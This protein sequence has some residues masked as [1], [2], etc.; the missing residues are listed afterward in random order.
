MGWVWSKRVERG[1]E[2]DSKER[3]GRVQRWLAD[4]TFY[5]REE[6]PRR[7]YWPERERE[8]NLCEDSHKFWQ[9]VLLAMKNQ[10]FSF[11]APRFFE[12][13][14]TKRGDRNWSKERRG[15]VLLV[16]KR[17][18]D[19]YRTRRLFRAWAPRSLPRSKERGERERGDAN[20]SSFFSFSPLDASEPRQIS[21]LFISSPSALLF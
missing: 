19:R 20:R 2:V 11:Q 13:R 3:R 4:A 10:N 15:K 7:I 9:V 17:R 1:G 8:E 16:V 12:F 21:P 14:E 18:E 5:N 6:G